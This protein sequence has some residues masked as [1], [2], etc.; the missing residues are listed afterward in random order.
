MSGYTI[1][2][3]LEEDGITVGS[4]T[5]DP[6]ELRVVAVQGVKLSGAVTTAVRRLRWVSHAYYTAGDQYRPAG[7]CFA[8]N[9]DGRA[10]AQLAM[11]QGVI[12]AVRAA[13]AA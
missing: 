9:A 5:A 6:G 7:I 1:S 2:V 10:M 13:Q 8:L 11:A 12:A 3:I 4:I